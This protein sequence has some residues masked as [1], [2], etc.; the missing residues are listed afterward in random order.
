MAAGKIFKTTETRKQVGGLIPQ[1]GTSES[2]W[3]QEEKCTVFVRTGGRSD[4]G[5]RWTPRMRPT[6]EVLPSQRLGEPA[7][8][9]AGRD[10]KLRIT[11]R[12]AGN[13]SN[14]PIK[15]GFRHRFHPI[16]VPAPPHGAAF[17]PPFPELWRAPTLFLRC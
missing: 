6:G 5:C 16:D 2:R 10:C 14:V 12:G 9:D 15:V 8:G 7:R 3:F 13:V 4:P 11:S 1:P 17:L